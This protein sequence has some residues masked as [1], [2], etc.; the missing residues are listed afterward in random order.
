MAKYGKVDG[1]EVVDVIVADSYLIAVLMGYPVLMDNGSGIGW[2]YDDG[3]L[4][5]PPERAYTVEEWRASCAVSS[6]HFVNA[7][8]HFT[9][10]ESGTRLDKKVEGDVEVL[11]LALGVRGERIKHSYLRTTGFNRTDAGVKD[12]VD[13]LP[14]LDDDR[15]D[16]VFRVAEQYAAGIPPAGDY[17][18]IWDD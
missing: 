15:A 8:T 9:V 17:V 13:F 10:G 18:V 16:A 11:P 3:I 1:G 14:Y 6:A 2:R 5:P 7:M 12:M 4:T